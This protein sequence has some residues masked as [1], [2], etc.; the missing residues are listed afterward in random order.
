[1]EARPE[2]WMEALVLLLTGLAI[3]WG[4]ASMGPG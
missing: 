4:I 1:M 2:F 3:V